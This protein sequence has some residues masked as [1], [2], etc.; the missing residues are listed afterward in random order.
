MGLISSNAQRNSDVVESRAHVIVNS[1][2]F[3]F[4]VG[5][6]F[7]KLGSLGPD[8][9]GWFD[10]LLLPGV[11]PAPHFLPGPEAADL[12]VGWRKPSSYSLLQLFQLLVLLR[13]IFEIGV[14]PRINAASALV[15][16]RRLNVDALIL[17]SASPRD[18]YF[19]LFVQRDTFAHKIVFA[20]ELPWRRSEEHTSELQSRLHLVCR[21]LLEKKKNNKYSTH[22]PRVPTHRPM[23]Q[24]QFSVFLANDHRDQIPRHLRA[25]YHLFSLLLDFTRSRYFPH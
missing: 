22:T 6:G 12:N 24:L 17:N 19:E 8:F 20:P 7:R 25:H 16:N 23:D 4:I 9:R 3:G 2:N 5:G 11:I 15:G 14:S 18:A 13:F 1:V 21:L 10:P